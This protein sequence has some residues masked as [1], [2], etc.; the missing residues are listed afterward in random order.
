MENIV[1]IQRFAAE[2][3]AARLGRLVFEFTRSAKSLDV[4]AVH[5]LRV[6]IRRFNQGLRTFGSLLPRREARKIRRQTR[7]LMRQA[8]EVRDR[9]IALAWLSRA[10]VSPRAQLWTRVQRGRQD[11][12]R[13]LAELLKQCHKKNFSSRW[14]SRLR[15]NAP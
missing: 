1:P 12:E 2:Q 5:D 11:A 6:S 10:G 4:E 8:A 9:D 7:R 13:G 14:R 3:I 15:L